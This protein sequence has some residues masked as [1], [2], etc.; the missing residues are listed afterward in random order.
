MPY[1]TQIA[2]SLQYKIEKKNRKNNNNNIQY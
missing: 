2:I 1:A